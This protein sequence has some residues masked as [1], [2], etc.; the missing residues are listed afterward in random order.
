MSNT[1]LIVATD[2]ASKNNQNETERRGAI[3]YVVD[4][5]DKRVREKGEA[6]GSDPNWTNN[7]AEYKAAIEALKW[8]IA[9]YDPATCSVLLLSDSELMIRQLQGEYDVNDESI[10]KYY[11]QLVTLVDK[12]DKFEPNHQSQATG[13]RIERADELASQAFDG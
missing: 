13:N 1:E 8:V 11:E 9:N 4:E 10:K 12:I 3:G 7:R 6:L 5:G 2:G